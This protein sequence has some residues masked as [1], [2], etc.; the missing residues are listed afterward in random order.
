MPCLHN[1][2]IQVA[3]ELFELA[4]REDI[5]NAE[6]YRRASVSRAY[7]SAYH[8]AL[9]LREQKGLSAAPSQ[10][11]EG[12]HAKLLADLRSADQQIAS[13]ERGHWRASIGLLETLRKRRIVADY[14]LG[15]KF[16]AGLA[17]DTLEIAN[18]VLKRL[19]SYSSA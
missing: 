11:G 7:Y 18:R 10:N 6:I 9:S 13:E 14:R 19:S 1:D 12:V 16:D 5:P 15:E 17:A 3:S 4:K 8:F 2:L